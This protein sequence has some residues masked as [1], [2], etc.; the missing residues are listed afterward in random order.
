VSSIVK[1]VVK[2]YAVCRFY[3]KINF[4]KGTFFIEYLQFYSFPSKLCPG[5]GVVIRCCALRPAA[6][7]RLIYN[8]KQEDFEF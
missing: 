8:Q 4:P 3:R 2:A 5:A 6:P 1:D 7:I